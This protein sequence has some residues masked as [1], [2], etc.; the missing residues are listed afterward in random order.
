MDR[1]SLGDPLPRTTELPSQAVGAGVGSK[2]LLRPPVVQSALEQGGILRMGGFEPDILRLGKVFGE[3]V[4]VEYSRGLPEAGPPEEPAERGSGR[5]R[6]TREG[7]RWIRTDHGRP[8]ARRGR[9]DL[10]LELRDD[11]SGL[12]VV[13]VLEVKNTNWGRQT[14]RNVRRNL[15]RHGQQMWRYLEP[16]VDRADAGE[17]AWVQGALVYPERPD[18]DRT[19]VIETVLGEG[20]KEGE[21]WGLTVL[22]WTDFAE[23]DHQRRG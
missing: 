18:P 4:A 11:E 8:P 13:V 22:W 14:T 3:L 23:G 1:R 10:R 2:Q 20:E 9:T 15:S 19:A 16:L 21:G 6:W 17:I 12:P 7:Y 5:V